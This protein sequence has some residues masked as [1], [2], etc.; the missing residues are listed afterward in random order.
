M[1]L[2]KYTESQLRKAVANNF[3]IR[4]ALQELNVIPAGGN[5]QVFR[6]AIKHFNID[7]SHFK[8]QGWSKGQSFPP[9]RDIDDYLSN[10]YE[11][12]SHKLR[13][14]LIR[15]G[16]FKPKCYSCNRE[17][18]E[19]NP[20]PL[21]LEH[22]DGNH[23]NNNLSNLTILCPNCHALTDTYRGKNKGSYKS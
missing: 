20:I 17:E 10:K 5:Y 23:Q 7:T 18:W 15:E 22:S 11:I 9:K 14:R 4:Q 21:E 19:G 6:K 8:G 3:S 2:K 13:K 12:G 16:Y 1:K